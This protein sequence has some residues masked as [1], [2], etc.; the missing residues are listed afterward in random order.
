M[1]RCSY[2]WNG[3]QV[4]GGVTYEAHY[5]EERLVVKE[6]VHVHHIVLVR[7]IVVLEIRQQLDLIKRL[8][9]RASTASVTRSPQYI[10]TPLTCFFS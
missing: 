5:D 2:G 1:K 8:G 9:G 7:R 6:V 10:R 4:R 3:I